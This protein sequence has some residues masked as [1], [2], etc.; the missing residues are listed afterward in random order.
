MINIIPTIAIKKPTINKISIRLYT[1]TSYDITTPITNKII[2]DT[3][4]NVFP[5]LFTLHHLI[6]TL[7]LLFISSTIYKPN[8]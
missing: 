6:F 4:F 5:N 3:N 2:P 1:I 8:G 7:I